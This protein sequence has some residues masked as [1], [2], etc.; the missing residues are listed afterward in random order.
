MSYDEVRNPDTAIWFQAEES[1]PVE[2]RF[3]L[4]SENS[5]IRSDPSDA[6]V[7]T[8]EGSTSRTVDSVAY[9]DPRFI[10]NSR[11]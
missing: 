10:Q 2:T 6:C 8:Q 9:D 1:T 5:V 11:V 3:N 4:G 7:T